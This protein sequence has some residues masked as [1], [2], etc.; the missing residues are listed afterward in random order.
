[1]EKEE[2]F[3]KLRK[4]CWS[5]DEQIQTFYADKVQFGFLSV[6]LKPD[7]PLGMTIKDKIIKTKNLH[8]LNKVEEFNKL[9]KFLSDIITN[10]KF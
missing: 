9:C 4:V 5:K 3:A 8:E 6:A 2:N 1:M 10:R 7:K